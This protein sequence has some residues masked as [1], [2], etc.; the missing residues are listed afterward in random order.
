MI[1]A[2]LNPAVTPEL[3]LKAYVQTYLREEIPQE[4][5]LRKIEGFPGFPNIDEQYCE[6]SP[7]MSRIDT[8]NGNSEMTVAAYFQIL[9]DTLMCLRLPGW[10]D[11]PTMQLSHFPQALFLR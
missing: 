9:E 4:A 7:D 11:S 5:I 10:S 6:K 3:T 1:L 2:V 8:A